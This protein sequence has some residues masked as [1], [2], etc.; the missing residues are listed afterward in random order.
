MYGTDP[1]IDNR[2]DDWDQDGVPIEWEHR[3]GFNPFIWEDHTSVDPDE[4][5][6]TNIEEF[7]TREFGSDPFRKDVFLELDFMEESPDSISSIVPEE[8]I[9]LLKNKEGYVFHYQNISL[10]ITRTLHGLIKILVES[11]EYD[12][13]DYYLN[14]LYKLSQ[15]YPEIKQFEQLYLL[16]KAIYLKSS[17]RLMEK[18]EAGAIL[19][20][21]TEEKIVDYEIT[22]EAMTN[23]CEILINELE[24]TFI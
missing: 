3:W 16:D 9:E 1:T 22:T 4:D 5:S 24:L 12:M 23:L 13:V 8:A 6:L 18:M 19:K 17:I 11:K 20:K 15:K 2:G 7:L 14:E 21:I 10:S